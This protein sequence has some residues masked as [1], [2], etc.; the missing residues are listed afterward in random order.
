[1]NVVVCLIFRRIDLPIEFSP[2]PYSNC[3]NTVVRFRREAVYVV[4]TQRKR[5][6]CP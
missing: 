1:M 4:L 2:A 3:A 6:R 5:W